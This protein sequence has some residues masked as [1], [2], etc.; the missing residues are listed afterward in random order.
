MS[1]MRPNKP[2]KPKG[3]NG[4]VETVRIGDSDLRIDILT[5]QGAAEF[6]GVS[7]DKLCADAESRKVPGQF[8]AGEW[9]FT[10][11]A[12][13]HWLTSPLTLRASDL[14]PPVG[15]ERITKS[16]PQVPT[17]PNASQ[18]S[19]LGSMADDDSLPAMVEE[20]YRRRTEE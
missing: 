19:S 15:M 14:G 5:L 17:T 13:Y 9:R 2:K 12:L 4:R 20:I 6:L 7:A 16:M 1:K 3:T 11:Q 18:L 10:K 8:V